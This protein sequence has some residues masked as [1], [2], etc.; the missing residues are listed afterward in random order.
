MI[1]YLG[2]LDDDELILYIVDHIKQKKPPVELVEGLEPVRL[3]FISL[4]VTF[5]PKFP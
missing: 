4:M 3:S 1:E 2:E 5:Y